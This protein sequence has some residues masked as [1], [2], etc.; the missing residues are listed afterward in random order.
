MAAVPR[1]KSPLSVHIPVG[2]TEVSDLVYCD[3]AFNAWKLP[4]LPDMKTGDK[5]TAETRK[6]MRV[7]L[8]GVALGE[9]AALQ[10]SLYEYAAR[11]NPARDYL[12]LFDRID[13]NRQQT[14]K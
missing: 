9:A 2:L 14:G 10:V 3:C 13:G 12:A 7:G 8:V 6:K 1:G 11:S 4:V 5:R